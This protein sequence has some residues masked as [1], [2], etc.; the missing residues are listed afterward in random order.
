MP[1]LPRPPP[2]PRPGARPL[3]RE[4]CVIEIGEGWA[5]RWRGELRLVGTF[6][7][8]RQALNAALHQAWQQ[9][10]DVLVQQRDG[11]FHRMRP[12]PPVEPEPRRKRSASSSHER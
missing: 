10:V 12:L 4:L 3:A 7:T 1:H 6:E 2:G 5:I 9:K 8:M 11:S